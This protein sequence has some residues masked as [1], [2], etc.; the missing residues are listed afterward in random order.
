[1]NIAAIVVTYNDDYK[2]NEWVS[3]HQLYKNN[4]YKHIIVDNGSNPEYL[5]KV[6]KEFSESIIIRRTSNG[7]STSAYNDGIRYALSDIN[8]DSI[9][10]I[11]NDIKIDDKSVKEL[12]NFLFSKLDLG[13]VTPYL[14]SK[15]SSI[16]ESG[17]CD[18]SY[19]LLLSSHLLNVDF[20]KIDNS[21]KIVEAVTG[22]MNMAKR[23]FYENV[24]LQDE[25][26]FM[27]S[28]EVDMS[29]R[30]LNFGYKM[31]VAGKAFAWHNHINK[32]S[33][34]RSVDVFML[35]YRNKLY[36][37][38]KHFGLI[39]LISIFCFQIL[40]NLINLS[41]MKY[42]V[43]IFLAYLKGSFRGLV[44]NMDNDSIVI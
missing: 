22:G 1:M 26:L 9:M 29:I 32:C 15:N 23:E 3:H 18:I 39:K 10:L 34:E 37:A 43:Q 40:M 14:L 38:R 31:G 7:G 17:G 8:V 13:M 4:L 28:D 24:G 35:I 12:Y 27:Y 21:D 20:T 42:N 2:F 36:L 11:G 30:S 25:N 6:E 33:N 44:N 19:A 16:I 5:N 41:L